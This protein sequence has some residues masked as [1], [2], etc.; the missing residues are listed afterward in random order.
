MKY[1]MSMAV[2]ESSKKL[3]HQ[4]FN[5]I[6]I[7]LPIQRIKIFF[8]ILQLKYYDEIRSFTKTLIP[9]LVAMLEHECQFSLR[10]KHII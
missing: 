1:I 8:Q 6:R 9:N 10:M 2:I 3:I 5:N 7:N 4:T